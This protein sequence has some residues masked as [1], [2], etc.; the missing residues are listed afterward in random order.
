LADAPEAIAAEI[1]PTG[2]LR[3]AINTGNML[4]VT[5]SDDAGDPVGVAPDLAREIASRLAVP[6]RLVP[7]ARPADL[8]DAASDGVWDIGLI[9]AEPVRA[10]KIAFSQAYAEIEACYLVPAG[11]PLRAVAD[12]DRPGV[13]IAVAAGSAYD[14]WLDRNLRHATLVRSKSTAEAQAVFAAKGL[15]VLAALREGLLPTQGRL[16]GARILP[17]RFMAVQQAVGTQKE[18]RAAAAFL[19]AFVEEAK[20]SG[21]IARLID[22]HGMTGRLAVAP[23]VVLRA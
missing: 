16:E 18:K 1:A 15:E 21:L 9:G 2:V 13:R 4:L 19:G 6:L 3:A 12:V 17:G 7:F 11:S 10:R 20:A 8:A 14:L 23:P 5:G 22:R